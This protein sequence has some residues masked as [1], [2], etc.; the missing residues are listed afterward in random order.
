MSN[1]ML[2]ELHFS[3][4]SFANQ[5]SLEFIKIFFQYYF[6]TEKNIMVFLAHELTK[7]V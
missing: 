1:G 2:C 6:I 3:I 5:I 7:K 4:P